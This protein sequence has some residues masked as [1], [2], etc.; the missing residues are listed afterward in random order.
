MFY[1]ITWKGGGRRSQRRVTRKIASK[2]LP[3]LKVS[4]DVYLL[5][6]GR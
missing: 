4:Y 3:F 2:D 1:R 5:R 6:R